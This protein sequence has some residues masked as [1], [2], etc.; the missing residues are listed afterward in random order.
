VCDN[1]NKEQK[2]NRQDW[3]KGTQN[4]FVPL[5]FFYMR[6]AAN[7]FYDSRKVRSAK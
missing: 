2:S 4:S 5:N 6:D 1:A 3:K 7:T